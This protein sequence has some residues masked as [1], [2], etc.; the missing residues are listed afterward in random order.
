MPQRRT[1]VAIVGL[2][3]FSALMWSLFVPVFESPDET[4]A[5]EYGR[6]YARTWELP[7]LTQQSLPQGV[8][9]WEPLYFYLLGTI[10]KAMNAPLSDNSKY[11]FENA[12]DRIRREQPQNFLRHEQS[13]FL[14]HWDEIGRSLHAMRLLSVLLA[15]GSV[16][17]IYRMGREVFSESSWIPLVAT[18]L[19]AFNPQF[20]FFS[21]VLNVVNMVTLT[22]SIFLWLLVRW[23]KLSSG[24]LHETGRLGVALGVAIL[25]KMTALAFLPMTCVVIMWKRKRLEKPLASALLVFFLAFMVVGGWYLVR[26]YVLYGEFSGTKAHVLY[27]FGKLTNPFLEE[28]G[29]L[30]FLISYP[31]TQWTTLW[32]GFGWT[33]IYLPAVFPL[34]MLVIYGHGMIGLVQALRQKNGELSRVEKRQL[35]VLLLLVCSVWVGITKVIFL[36]EVFHGKDLFLVAGPL[37][38]LTVAGLKHFFLNMDAHMWLGKRSWSIAAIVGFLAV[39]WIRQPEL[40]RFMKGTATSADGGS[41]VVISM[42]G[43]LLLWLAWAMAKH[44]RVRAFVHRRLSCRE[45]NWIMGLAALAAVSDIAILFGLV[46]PSLY[47]TSV[48]QLVSM[49]M[50]R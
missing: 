42:I 43:M 26:N 16:W 13:E 30:N 48:W 34:V 46:V 8:H 1:A 45:G 24:S 36:V 2:F 10:A 31:K 19:F 47:Q 39:F 5:Y 14:F 28:V 15:T 35:T 21:G 38:L 40:A 20:V 6:Y 3:F 32:S 18:T 17:M 41:L 27:R 11:Y 37:A 29:L 33:T 23:V 9:H 7:V 22:A 12:W 4:T 44:R 49:T 50:N 25:S